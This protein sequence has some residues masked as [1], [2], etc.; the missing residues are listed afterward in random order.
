[1]PRLEITAIKAPFPRDELVGSSL[2]R[3]TSRS[4]VDTEAVELEGWV[5]ARRRRVSMIEVKRDGRSI[6]RLPVDRPRPDIAAVFHDVK[7]ANRCGFRGLIRVSDARPR[8]DLAVMAVLADGTRLPL[9]ILQ[10]RRAWPEQAARRHGP[11]VS[12]IIPCYNQGHLLGEAIESV[13]AQ[14]YPHVEVIVVDDGSLD[15]TQEIAARYPGVRGVRQSNRGSAEARNTGLRLSRGG[16]VVFLDADDRLLPEALET[17]LEQFE[18]HPESALVVGQSE[19]IDLQGNP[20]PGPPPRSVDR[21]H[22]LRLFDDNYFGTPANGMYRRSLF[23]DAGPFDPS[24]D[25]AED[26]DMYLRITRDHPVVFHG[27]TVSQYRLHGRNKSKDPL[28]MLRV[29]KTV[30][31]RQRRYASRMAGGQE[32]YRAGKA[33]WNSFYGKPL[34]EEVS[35]SIQKHAWQQALRGTLTLIR[36]YPGGLAAIPRR[37]MAARGQRVAG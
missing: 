12:V 24:V 4:T 19:L 20:L 9:G 37:G 1:V 36:Y 13:L 8:F 10:G 25:G 21:D 28:L 32:A 23:S 33:F 3:P 35:R 2:E 5:L 31:R 18:S 14:T 11:F 29:T 16:F 34:V 27:R 6:L 15:N 17:G 26:Y 7:G 30:L 22:Y